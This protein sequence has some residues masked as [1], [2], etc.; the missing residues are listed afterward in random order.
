MNADKDKRRVPTVSRVAGD[1]IIELV[2]DREQRRTGLVVSR[3]GGL[4]N[5]EQEVTVG[6]GEILVPYSARNN[7]ISNECVLLPSKPGDFGDKGD[8]L[9]D[10]ESFLHRYVDLSPLFEKL[11]AHYV[12]MTWVYDAFNEVPYLRLRGDYGTGKTRGLIA[13]GS[14]CYKPFFAAGAS[15]TSAIFR[16]LDAFGGTLLFDEADFRFSDA[17]AELVKILNNGNVRGLPVLRTVL[18]RH[19][20]FN[21]QAFKVFGPKI[22]AMRG[23]Y[24]DKA[25]ESRFLTEETGGRLLRHDIPIHLPESLKT[26]ALELRDRLLH[27]RLCKFF[28]IKTDPSAITP[29]IEPRLNQTVLSLLSLVDDAALRSEITAA[30]VRQ[31]AALAAERGES[32]EAGLI[33]G[34]IDAFAATANAFVSVRDVTDHFNTRFGSE[35]GRPFSSKWIGAALRKRLHVETQRSHGVYVIPASEKTKIDA[36]AARYGI[37]TR[38]DAIAHDAPQEL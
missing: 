26:E 8:L 32:L 36:L 5:I 13:I 15:S 25:L 11:A 33:Q 3:F 12:L 30:L 20:E 21:P 29:D 16:T 10:I 17:T 9:R 31:N 7:L 6:T 4:W 2:Y 14:L 1:T 37:A 27:F 18:N 34:V 22:V 23:S 35:Y 24:D 19:K 28:D 38:A